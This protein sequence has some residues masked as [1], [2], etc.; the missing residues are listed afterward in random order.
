MKISRI[1]TAL[2]AVAL[3][4]FLATDVMAQRG[5]GRPGGGGQGGRGGGPGGP[6]G[7]GFGGRGGPGGGFG[8]PSI[9]QAVFGLLRV[10]QV[11]EEVELMPDQEEAIEKIMEQGRGQRPDFNFQE[12]SEDERRAFFEKMQKEREERSAK[13]AEQLEEVLL[14]DQYDRV[15]EIAIQLMDV[16]A[17][18][19][20][21]VAED[22]KLSDTQQSE[23][24][25]LQTSIREDMRAKMQEIFQGGG[26]D[27]DAM[28]AKFAELREENNKKYMEVLTSEQRS[29]FDKMKGEKFDMPEGAGRAMFGGGGRGGPG[30]GGF[31]GRGGR[32][33][34]P[35]GGPGGDGGGRQR[36]RPSAE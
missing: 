28:R 30:G 16:Q 35:G 12:A 19:I 15:R 27:R 10:D 23:L 20:D 29:D 22:L 13:M 18:M 25:D 31:G 3:M 5:G 11:K 6:G 1:A 7:G 17:L 8:T 2:L 21:E 32:G 9:G 24:E 14:P 34:G 4:A 36:R 26:G 33:G